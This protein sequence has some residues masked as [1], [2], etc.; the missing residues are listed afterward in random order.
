MI[1]AIATDDAAHLAILSSRIHVAWA[2][3]SGGWLGV[4][5]D[6][7]YS[8]SRC[9]DPFPFPDPPMALT[10]K[11]RA[12]GE[13]LDAHRK[14]VLAAHP[15][16]TLTGLYNVLEKF[17]AGAPLS[18]R[19]TR[20]SSARGLV[21]DPE[22]PAR[23]GRPARRRGLWLAGRDLPDEDVLARLVALNAE[24]A[25]EEAAGRVR[26]LRP[27]YQIPRFA[28]GLS[29]SARTFDFGPTVVAIDRAVPAFPPDRDEQP[30]AVEALLIAAGRPM[31]AAEVARGFRR[32]GRRIEPRIEAVLTTLAR[33]GWI[34]ALGDGRYAARR[35]A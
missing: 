14:R 19:R 24:R 9:F 10:Q 18:P 26:W 15:D 12:A 11:L 23:R 13:E 20:T 32:G 29:E 4:G 28:K 25:R 5:N 35:A 31:S 1:V 7:R 2:I 30:L 17:R 34:G 6:P 33:Y 22:G 3:A 21:L 27:E 16:L 8:K